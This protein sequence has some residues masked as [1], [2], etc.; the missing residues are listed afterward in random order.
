MSDEIKG[1]FVLQPRRLD[2][3]DIMSHAPIVRELWQYL[4]RNVNWRDNDRNNIPRGEGFFTLGDIQ[5]DL[6]WYVGYRKMRYSK[7]QLTKSLR[8]LS[9]GNAIATT[10]ETRGIRVKVLNYCFY[11]D[12]ANYEGNNE[13][14][15]KETRRQ[16]EGHTILEERNN[17]ENIEE[18]EGVLTFDCNGKVNQWTLTQKQVDEWAEVYPGVDILAECKRA[19]AWT[20]ANTK[21]TANGMKRFLNGWISR[22]VNSNRYVSNQTTT[23]PIKNME[24]VK[25]EPSTW[26]VNTQLQAVKE[27]IRQIKS[28]SPGEHCHLYDFITEEEA[29]ELQDLCRKQ[30]ELERKLIS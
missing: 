24:P 19:K 18:E 1:G 3:S 28:R 20:L 15:A 5:E 7:P 14:N 25:R 11:Q 17:K 27:R 9:E 8:R 2:S 4:C 23:K 30:K 29:Q 10:K 12:P 26:E 6:S 13:G 22:A 21:K 16:R